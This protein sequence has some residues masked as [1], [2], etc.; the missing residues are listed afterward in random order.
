[1]NTEKLSQWLALIA[2]FGVLA[3]IVFLVVE[4]HQNTDALRAE[5]QRAVFAGAQQE[6][7]TSMQ[8][9]EI[10]RLMALPDA[11]AT[12]EQRLR[13]DSF[14]TAALR[15]REFAWSQHQAGILDDASWATEREVISL[16]VGS[17]RN[18]RWWKEV[19]RLQF[20]G[21]FQQLVSS[22]VAN[23]PIHPYWT[24]VAEWGDQ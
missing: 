19:G 20:T 24:R 3:G 17:E 22:I 7:Y 10:F 18:R 2:N 12:F 15:A 16:L 21:E 8:Y 14:L 11:D 9:P 5:S 23:E 4:I 6:L 1:M 13:I